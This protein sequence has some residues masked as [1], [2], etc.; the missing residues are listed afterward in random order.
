MRLGSDQQDWPRYMSLSTLVEIPDK[1][2]PAIKYPS[3]EA[4]I[5]SAKYLV[6]TG[7]PD[8]GRKLFSVNGD[9][10]KKFEAERARVGSITAESVNNEAATMRTQAGESKL[11]KYPAWASWSSRRDAIYNSYLGIR[12]AVDPRFKSMVDAIV[13][14]GG[15]ILFANGTVP[16]ELGVGVLPDGGVVGGDNRVGKW[17]M[18]LGGR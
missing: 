4:A 14:T 16:S 6:A 11:K 18:E 3:M 9:I 15:E 2:D 8:L 5:A 12:Y 17:M 10:H 1:D 7:T 13:A